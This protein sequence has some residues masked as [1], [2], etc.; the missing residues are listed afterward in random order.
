MPVAG[1]GLAEENS[2]S[3]SA[4]LRLSC[5]NNTPEVDS[6]DELQ[7]E[8]TGARCQKNRAGSQKVGKSSDSPEIDCASSSP[9]PADILNPAPENPV[10]T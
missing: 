2:L 8:T 6:T 10:A 9:T 1:L 5:S 4:K 3:D 7:I